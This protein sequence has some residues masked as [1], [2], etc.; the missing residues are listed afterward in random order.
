MSLPVSALIAALALL[1]SHSPPLVP[2]SVEADL[3]A[4]HV[5]D[6][7]AHFAHDVDALLANLPRN[8]P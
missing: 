4:M 6:R 3:L 8:S 5:T 7:K 2:G 1:L